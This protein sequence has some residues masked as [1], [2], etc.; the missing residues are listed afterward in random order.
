MKTTSIVTIIRENKT[1][2]IYINDFD[3]VSVPDLSFIIDV[4][5]Y[6]KLET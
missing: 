6:E 1:I 4:E 3:W 5:V 2:L